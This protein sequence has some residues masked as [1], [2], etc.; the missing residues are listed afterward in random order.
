MVQLRVEWNALPFSK[1]EYLT[2]MPEVEET[3]FKQLK[4]MYPTWPD[5]K[6]YLLS[7][8]GGRLAVDPYDEHYELIHYTKASDVTM[9]HVRLMR[10]VVW[11]VLKHCPVSVMAPKVEDTGCP[12]I[13]SKEQVILLPIQEGPMVTQ[14]VDGYTGITMIHTPE[15]LEKGPG[16]LQWMQKGRS[17]TFIKGQRIYNVDLFESDGSVKLVPWFNHGEILPY[18]QPPTKHQLVLDYT[19]GVIYHG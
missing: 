11:D 5:L 14:F 16:P 12:P 4:Q 13:F 15:S 1:T 6:A 9:R 19:T 10:S 8:E 2:I 18:L 7:D 17:C 3:A